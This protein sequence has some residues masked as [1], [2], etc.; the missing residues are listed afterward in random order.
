MVS[1][2]Q[3]WN[4]FRKRLMA[5]GADGADGAGG[6]GDGAGG[7]GDGARELEVDAPATTLLMST[8]SG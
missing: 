3:R 2:W 5:G 8:G 1:L 4:Y 7:A 6:V